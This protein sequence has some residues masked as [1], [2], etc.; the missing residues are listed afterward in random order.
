MPRVAVVKP[1]AP[2]RQ[3][4]ELADVP[5]AELLGFLQNAVGGYIEHVTLSPG[6]AGMYVN[7]EGLLQ[8]LPMNYV[9]TSLYL[10][11][12]YADVPIVG[13]LVL[14]GGPDREG[15][16]TDFPNYLLDILRDGGVQVVGP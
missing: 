3:I 2:D 10:A 8:Q 5:Q 6:V 1:A 7:E 15:N 4:A 9:G 13:T 14:V 12:G 16:D 11:A